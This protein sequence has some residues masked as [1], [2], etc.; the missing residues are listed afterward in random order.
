V[1]PPAKQDPAFKW[2]LR[3]RPARPDSSS[4]EVFSLAAGRHGIGADP[5]NAIF[6]DTRGVS[7]FH[8]AIDCHPEFCELEDLRSKNGTTV[9]GRAISREKVVAGDELG[10]AT[11]RATLELVP[12][13]DHELAFELPA[14]SGAPGTTLRGTY[15]GDSGS[16]EQLSL[17]LFRCLRE[18]EQRFRHR[19]EPDY[20]GAAEVLMRHL[21]ASGA[22]VIE[23]PRNLAFH[24]L[25]SVGQAPR[26]PAP[27]AWNTAP[28]IDGDPGFRFMSLE[29]GGLAVVRREQDGSLLGIA[30][31]GAVGAI[32]S[33]AQL[34]VCLLP[35]GLPAEAVAWPEPRPAAEVELPP[36]IVGGASPAMKEVYRQVALVAPSPV[37]ILIL[38]ETGVGKEHLARALHQHSP[39]ASRP[40]VAVN[41]AAL[42]AE[43]LEAEMFG[44]GQGVATGV[45]ARRGRFLEADHGTLFLDEIGDM[46]LALQAKLLRVLQEGVVS[47]L[48]EKPV[49]IDVRVVAASHMEFGPAIAER[50]FREDLY[51]RLA[52]YVL[53]VPPLRERIDDLPALL[54]RFLQDMAREAGRSVRGVTVKAIEELRAQRWPGNVRQL[55]QVA[56]RL[57]YLCPRGQAIDSRLVAEALAAL[58]GAAAEETSASEKPAFRLGEQGLEEYLGELEKEIVLRALEQKEGNRTRAAA[59]LGISRNGLT[60]R[61]E[62]YGLAADD[63]EPEA[64]AKA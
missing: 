50:R 1:A 2:T 10:F 54:G 64:A 46:P 24:V 41:C 36:G 18:L 3:L 26:L 14:V 58:P 38:G 25:A 22:Q 15:S 11:V 57:I 55:Q 27:D 48:G 60:R 4:G 16:S 13:G 9:N 33:P 34:A 31:A 42:P 62:R 7:R 52:G 44:I 28:T 5:S 19:A 63:E 39:R 8:A 59:L 43:L 32:L 45:K 29:A 6:L 40:F 49:E 35:F 30:L 23:R 20:G 17:A 47:P 12:A 53:K 21:G 37:P 56:R 51:Y 61:L